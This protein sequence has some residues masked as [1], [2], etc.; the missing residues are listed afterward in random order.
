MII[1][2]VVDWM[3][4]GLL[5]QTRRPTERIKMQEEEELTHYR[6]SPEDP[7]RIPLAYAGDPQGIQ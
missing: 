2:V 5:I 3:G 4:E 6:I 7:L 1:A